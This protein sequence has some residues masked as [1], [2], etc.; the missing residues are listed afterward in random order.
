MK[1]FGLVLFLIIGL[2]MSIGLVFASGDTA[3]SSS[4]A[5]GRLGVI[6]DTIRTL[7]SGG[8]YTARADRNGKR[9]NAGSASGAY[10][11]VNGTWRTWAKQADVDTTV[12]PTADSA[13]PEIQDRVAGVN[14]TA[15]LEEHDGQIEAV[16]V[17][18]Y[19]P[20]AWGNDSIMDSVP[21]REF[22]NTFTVRQYQTKWMGIYNEK[23]AAAG[24]PEP[25]VDEPASDEPASG[26]IDAPQPASALAPG[27]D[28]SAPETQ[29]DTSGC[30]GTLDAT[31]QWALPAPRDTMN[32]AL[33]NSPHHDYPAWDFIVDTGTPIFAVTGGTVA[34]TTSFAGN[35]DRDGCGSKNPP[36]GCQSCGIGITIQHPD[37]LR[38]TYCHNIALHAAK[39]DTIAPGQ[40]IATSGDT[41]KSGT[42][43][44][45]LE[46][47]INGTR[48][49]PQSLV[50]ALYNGEPVP[51]PASL[52]RSG[53]SS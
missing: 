43:H 34:R 25:D 6:L 23:L 38:H 48:H 5:C 29:G 51:N 20:I 19:Y 24:N 22:G 26:D 14:I 31:G 52:P 30:S 33:I 42:D 7:E 45:H 18:W 1:I 35:W 9:P 16:P 11:Y 53:C 2:V 8:D 40:L 50:L 32:P 4:Y 13:P 47:R 28:D 21:S 10:Q 36:Q 39:G 3:S 12:Y 44:L 27:D 49:C 15:I 37:G 17:I 46:F 41:G